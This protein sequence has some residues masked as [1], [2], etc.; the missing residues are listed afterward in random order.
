MQIKLYEMQQKSYMHRAKFLSLSQ[1]RFEPN[2]TMIESL[3]ITFQRYATACNLS[4]HM[5]MTM[6]AHSM[7]AF[8]AHGLFSKDAL[9]S[10]QK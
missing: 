2:H 7:Y 5:L 10:T 3:S 4:E 1:I 8:A 6:A 9:R